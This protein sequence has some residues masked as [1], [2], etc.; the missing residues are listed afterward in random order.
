MSSVAL[1]SPGDFINVP[2]VSSHPLCVVSTYADGHMLCSVVEFKGDWKWLHHETTY[3]TRANMDD[4]DKL[5]IL[6]HYGSW[7]YADKRLKLMFQETIIRILS[8][9]RSKSTCK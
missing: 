6:S 9:R 4:I 7:A 8:N 3:M 1:Y 2:S 5:S